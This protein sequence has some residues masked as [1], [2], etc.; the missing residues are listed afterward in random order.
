MKKYDISQPVVL[1]KGVYRLNSERNFDYQLNRVINWDGGRLEDV[2]PIASG[3][4][5][6]AD[7]K[8]E[9]I[10]LGDRAMSEELSSMVA[11]LAGSDFDMEWLEELR[12]ILGE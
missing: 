4:H 5:T 6:S 12:R 3:I 11:D 1:K 10:A 8:R 9:L 2:E 7:W